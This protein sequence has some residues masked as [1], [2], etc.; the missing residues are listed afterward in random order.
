[1]VLHMYRAMLVRQHVYVQQFAV[2]VGPQSVCWLGRLSM[3]CHCLLSMRLTR[4][5]FV[6]SGVGGWVGYGSLLVVRQFRWCRPVG[7]IVLHYSRRLQLYLA[8]LSAL[9]LA[10]WLGVGELKE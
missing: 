3:H 1:M 6:G 7:Q 4:F 8:L 5:A 2:H 9:L 10:Y